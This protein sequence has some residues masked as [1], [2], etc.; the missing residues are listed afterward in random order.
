MTDTVAMSDTLLSGFP[1]LRSAMERRLDDL[2]AQECERWCAVD[3]DLQTGFDLLRGFITNGGKRLRPEFAYW[4]FVG[5]GGDPEDLRLL[6]LTAALEMLHTFALVHDDVMDGS[7]VRRHAPTL[8]QSLQDSH[9][10]GQWRG[11]ARRFSEGMAVLL[12][13][14][15]FV[16]AGNF[17]ATLPPVVR[18]GFHEM[19][20]ELHVGQYLDLLGA[21]HPTSPPH[22]ASLVTRYKTAKYSVERPLLLGSALAA[23]PE[24]PASWPSAKREQALSRYGLAVGEAFQLRD[25]LLGA[26]GDPALTG[27]PSGDDFRESKETVL[28]QHARRWVQD[29]PGAAADSMIFSRLG[30]ASLDD[31]EIEDLRGLLVRSGA[32]EAVEQ[33]INLL[34][35][36]GQRDL[37]QAGLQPDA[38]AALHDLAH[39]AAWRVQ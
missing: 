31:G 28:V 9:I 4:G 23:C 24:Q 38:M 22:R 29:H 20:I 33:R 11:E 39:R 3:P 15:A 1:S 35:K 19:A 36:R 13:D 16:Y 32:C 26:F 30:T 21:A 5:S 25:D 14:L 2:L 18:S 34:T 10:N 8:H 6:E 12:G 7:T 37:L 17:C 27:K